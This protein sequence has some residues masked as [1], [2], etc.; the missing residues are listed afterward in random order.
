MAS[1]CSSG[2]RTSSQMKCF[3]CR[4]PNRALWIA[5][6]WCRLDSVSAL[7]RRDKMPKENEGQRNE[8]I[9]TAT[10]EVQAET[11]FPNRPG[12][13]EAF[14]QAFDKAR[15]EQRPASRRELGR[16]RSR[17]LFLLAGAGLAVLL[18]FFGLFSSSTT[19]KRANDTP[20]HTPDLGRRINPEQARTGQTGSATPLLSAQARQPDVAADQNVTPEDVGRTA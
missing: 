1:Y 18:L 4:S 6:R 10:E 2:R 3:C 17:S 7:H 13:R 14:R 20:P 9:G 15:R 16:D 11:D 8:M 5:R 12:W 19:K